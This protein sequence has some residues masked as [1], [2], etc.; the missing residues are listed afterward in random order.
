[1]E[2][3]EGELC[4]GSFIVNGYFVDGV[5]LFNKQQKKSTRTLA[6]STLH[7]IVSPNEKSYLFVNYDIFILSGDL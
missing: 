4:S 6:H 7:E 5:W 1:M 2:K 3:I